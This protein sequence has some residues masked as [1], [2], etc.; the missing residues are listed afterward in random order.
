MKTE[1]RIAIAD[2]ERDTRE[3]LA[4]VL[5]RQG[6]QVVGTCSDGAE[7][8]KTIRERDPRAHHHRHPHAASRRH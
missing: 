8:L 2:D 7:L 3:F 6:H 1:F 5:T 4:E